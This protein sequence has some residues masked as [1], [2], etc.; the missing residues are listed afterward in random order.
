MFMGIE[1]TETAMRVYEL[2][3]QVPAGRVT[4]YGALAKAAGVP[5]APRLVGAIMRGNPYAP[6]VPCHRVV[7]SDGA[8]GGYSGSADE[9]I[10]KKVSMLESE[11]V[12]VKD[13]KVQDFG[14]VFF[15]DFSSK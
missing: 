4:T 6:K 11:G 12:R 7:K 1:S 15:D 8:I 5:K 9:N 13:G 10:R 3:R 2:L 14:K